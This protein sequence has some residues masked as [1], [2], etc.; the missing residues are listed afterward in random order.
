[1]FKQ[2]KLDVV[3][4]GI[5][6]FLGL[7]FFVLTGKFF[8]NINSTCNDS[9]IRNGFIAIQVLS[10]CLFIAGLSYFICSWMSECYSVANNLRTSEMYLTIFLVIG[11][12][13]LGISSAV[14]ASYAKLKP[15]D[16]PA[17]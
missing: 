10:G 11:V 16:A 3:V 17:C 14:Y 9:T 6:G 4:M 13:I 2:Q 15:K 7:I 12:F 5:F 1:M 8:N